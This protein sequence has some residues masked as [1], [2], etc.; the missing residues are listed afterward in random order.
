M[1]AYNTTYGSNGLDPV[2][3]VHAGLWR[4]ASPLVV[5]TEETV[6]EEKGKKEK[7]KKDK[8]KD[9]KKKRPASSSQSSSSEHRPKERKKNTGR[10][11]HPSSCS[12]MS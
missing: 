12:L 11:L 6:K 10:S 7:A 4:H 2:D 8:H 9:K 1:Q 5:A 3:H